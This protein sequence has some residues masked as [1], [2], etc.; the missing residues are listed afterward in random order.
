MKIPCI[1][2]LYIVFILSLLVGFKAGASIGDSGKEDSETHSTPITA[3]RAGQ[4]NILLILVDEIDSDQPHLQNVWLMINSKNN[5][6]V[7]LLPILPASKLHFSTRLNNLADRFKL[8]QNGEPNE[9]FW[10][11]LQRIDTWWNGYLIMD[12]QSLQLL[13]EYLVKISETEDSTEIVDMIQP[14]HPQIET[15][16]EI[17]RYQNLCRTIASYNGRGSFYNVY[18]HLKDYIRSD[19]KPSQLYKI[20]KQIRS[21][22]TNLICNFPTIQA[23]YQ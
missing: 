10:F 9:S 3:S 4:N 16:N 8:T 5:P 1:I 22:G 20:W 19:M 14:I 13:D 11:E 18:S 12:D 17:T 7:D 2:G 6:R 15:R 21:Y 23:A